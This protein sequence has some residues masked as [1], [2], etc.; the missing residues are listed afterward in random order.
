[1]VPP[2]TCFLTIGSFSWLSHWKEK[3]RYPC[4]FLLGQ[5][6]KNA[7]VLL[8]DLK[9]WNKWKNFILPPIF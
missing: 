9:K 1:M 2:M 3:I 4:L 7:F 6:E 8:L 5:T